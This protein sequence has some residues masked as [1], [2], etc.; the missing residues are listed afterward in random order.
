M[1]ACTCSVPFWVIYIRKY[2]V[3]EGFW[4]FFCSADLRLSAA[5]G[6]QLDVALSCHVFE[7][8]AHLLQSPP[9]GLLH[10]DS[11]PQHVLERGQ[12]V[13]TDVQ[14]KLL[15]GLHLSDRTLIFQR[16]GRGYR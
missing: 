15:N 9:R 14:G 5:A 3:N 13:V 12:E 1:K 2:Q 10:V 6:E 8:L 4:G 16:S 11:G 7:G